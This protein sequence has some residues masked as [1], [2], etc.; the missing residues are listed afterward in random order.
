MATLLRSAFVI[1]RR[2]F[3]ATV[4]SKTFLLFLLGPLF[5][6]LMGVIFGGISG[7]A[8]S[9]AE[10]PVIAVVASDSDFRALAEARRRLDDA[11]TSSTM[12]QLRHFR[13]EPDAA[14]Q[15]QRLLALESPPVIAVLEGSL[16]RPRL[17]GGLEAEGTTIRHV[18][19]LVDI[20]RRDRVAPAGEVD[21]QLSKSTRSP[22]SLA[23][24]RALTARAGQTVL[25]LL[26]ILLS[27]MLLSQLID[28]KANKI[29]EVLA[30]AVP[31]DAIFLGKLFAM[32]VMSLLGIAVWTATGAATIAL[33]TD[34]GL[35]ALP[36]PATGWPAF[37]TLAVVYFM[38]SYLLLGSVFLGIGGQASTA[39][40]VQT[41]S[42]PAT[43]A[44]VVV[45]ALAATAVGV[46]DS[47]RALAAAVFPLS[48][49]F[50]MI[51]RAA[52]QPQIWPHLVAIAW[53]ALWVAL[54]VR[55]AS[56]I[57]RRSVLK[58]GPR[59]RFWRRA[60]KA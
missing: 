28:E 42:M 3:T 23:P 34:Q 1:A 44:Q 7:A 32:L 55:V 13:P 15:R 35:S 24:A 19:F 16:D 12:L 9:D 57:F 20:A 6:V 30:A 58:S 39:R 31:I 59:R 29:I 54:I 60:A 41:L 27:G 10:R 26:T 22:G 36:A 46:P 18:R 43:M 50:V 2:D 33:M 11:V 17:I 56:R 25:F 21:V 8:I 14:A 48:S 37:L 40:E 38:M 47:P 52:E 45:F 49:P 4:F 51:A 5:P 53:Q